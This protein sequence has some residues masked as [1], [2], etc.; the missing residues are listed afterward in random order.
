MKDNMSDELKKQGRKWSVGGRF[1]SLSPSHTR[2]PP[3]CTRLSSVC[4]TGILRIFTNTL[5]LELPFRSGLLLKK[6]NERIWQLGGKAINLTD[7][8]LLHT[9]FTDRRSSFFTTLTHVYLQ[10]N[11]CNFFGNSSTPAP[12]PVIKNTNLFQPQNQVM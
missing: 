9:N 6:S 12:W 3:L 5:F 7:T 10:H 11:N 8:A 2:P 4:F 1:S